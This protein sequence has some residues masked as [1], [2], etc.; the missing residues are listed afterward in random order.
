MLLAAATLATSSPPFGRACR[1]R[2]CISD[3]PHR[4]VEVAARGNA[5]VA[6]MDAYSAGYLSGSTFV[7]AIIGYVVGRILI[8]PAGV[9]EVERLKRIAGVAE[10][11]TKSP[12]RLR[13]C[14]P[15]VLALG[16]ALVGL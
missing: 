9:D 10:P 4:A 5:N 8:G 7:L 2:F 13:G 12:S 14:V 15:Y 16:G 6:P 1:R 3:P 11:G